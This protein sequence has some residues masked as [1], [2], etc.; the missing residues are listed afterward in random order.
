MRILSTK[1]SAAGPL[2]PQAD[3]AAGPSRRDAEERAAI[4]AWL[5]INTQYYV[6]PG[7]PVVTTW[8]ERELVADGGR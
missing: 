1:P 5:R 8:V 7:E 6:A 4:D 3:R 2:A